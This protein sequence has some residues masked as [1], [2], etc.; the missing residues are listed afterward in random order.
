MKKIQKAFTLVEIIVLILIVSLIII[1]ASNI[2][3]SNN[4]DIMLEKQVSIFQSSLEEISIIKSSW[5][6][7]NP[8]IL[9]IDWEI[10][11]NENQWNLV[12]YNDWLVY[13]DK[14]IDNWF[15]LEI[16]CKNYS[17]VIFEPGN[18]IKMSAENI[19]FTPENSACKEVLIKIISPNKKEKTLEINTISGAKRSF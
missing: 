13:F 7:V 19:G 4:E 12:W 16:E 2:N 8:W 9:A 11:F 14:K 5:K 18:S 17:W 10:E 3:L 15:E 1:S 6:E